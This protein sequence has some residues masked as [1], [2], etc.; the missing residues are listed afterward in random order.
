MI[1]SKF[2]ITIIQCIFLNVLLYIW[3]LD[4]AKL[5]LLKPLQI[6]RFIFSF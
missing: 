6:S 4:N 3:F 2:L 1:V 5:N